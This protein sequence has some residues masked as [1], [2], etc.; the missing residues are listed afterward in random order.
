MSE[1][2]FSA[3]KLNKIDPVYVQLIIHVKK[4]ILSGALGDGDRLPSRRDTAGTLCI[5]PNTVQKAYKLMEEQGFLVTDGNTGSVIKL[6]DKAVRAI[7]DELTNDMFAS[8]LR[9]CKD[10]NMSFK[11]VIDLLSN[12]WEKD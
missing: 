11:Q 4:C 12:L 3:L 8:F 9:E 10:L 1:W 2:D 6:N 5:N 7:Q